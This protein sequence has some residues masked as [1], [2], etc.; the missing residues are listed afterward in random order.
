MNDKFIVKIG[1]LQDLPSKKMKRGSK[2]NQALRLLYDSVKSGEFVQFD[3]KEMRVNAM[4][5][6]SQLRSSVGKDVFS[7]GTRIVSRGKEWFL[8][9]GEH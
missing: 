9:R 6:R 7:R 1:K 4:S 5:L 8:I 3:A 2:V